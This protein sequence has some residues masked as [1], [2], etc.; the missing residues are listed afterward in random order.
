MP[1]Y[2]FKFQK[3]DHISAN[4]RADLHV[5]VYYSKGHSRKL[6]GR[7]RIPGLDP[8][9]RGEQELNQQEREALGRWL[10]QPEQIRKL[11]GCLRDTLFDINRVASAAIREGDVVA[12]QGETFVVVRIPVSRRLT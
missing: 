4:G 1:V 8:V 10:S 7:Y 11:E 6:I 5:H 3:A 12:E 2:T 9:F